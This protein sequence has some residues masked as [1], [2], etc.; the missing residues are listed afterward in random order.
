M[1][2]PRL[3]YLVQGYTQKALRLEMMDFIV[4]LITGPC[5]GSS[6]MLSVGRCGNV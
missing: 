3:L 1:D 2:R 5:P 6:H 4:F